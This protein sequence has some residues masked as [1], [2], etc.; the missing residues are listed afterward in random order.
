MYNV[1][2]VGG[3]TLHDTATLVASCTIHVSQVCTQTLLS[4]KYYSLM[5]TQIRCGRVLA[6]TIYTPKLSDG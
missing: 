6:V 1:A 5:N 4:T 3:Q 2:Y